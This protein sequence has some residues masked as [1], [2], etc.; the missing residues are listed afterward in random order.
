MN[1][2]LVGNAGNFMRLMIN[3][4]NKEGHRVFVLTEEPKKGYSL[5]KV[6]EVYH[7][8]Y[9]DACVREVLESIMPQV[10]VFW[11]HM[12]IIFLEQGGKH[13]GVLCSGTYEYT[14]ELYRFKERQVCLS[15][16]GECFWR[17]K[18]TVYDRG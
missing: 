8:S 9:E 17:W 11:G 18:R 14:D 4:L 2:L 5:K 7:F 3:R 12:T 1:I 13:S 16:F 10:V 15:F 6:F